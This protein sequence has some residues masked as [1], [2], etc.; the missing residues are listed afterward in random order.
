MVLRYKIK[1]NLSKIM[2]EEETM[3]N[4]VTVWN[5][6]ELQE[7]IK[8]HKIDPAIIPKYKNTKFCQA[9]VHKGYI[10]GT[11]SVISK[12]GDRDRA[13]FGF[14]IGPHN[15][16]FIDDTGVALACIN[17]IIKDKKWKVGSMERFLYDF[18]ETLIE[19]DLRYIEDLNDKLSNVENLIVNE[20]LDNFNDVMMG[21]RK[22]I[23][24]FHRYYSQLVDVGKEF[25]EN[26]NGFFSKESIM[27]FK[28]FTD[29][30]QQLKEEAQVLREYSTQTLEIYHSQ[31]DNVQNRIMKVLTIVTTIFTPV[32]ILSAWYGM[33][34]EN[35]PELHWPYGYVAVIA[36]SILMSVLIM[37]YINHKKL[38]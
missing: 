21:L 12:D 26:E 29:R 19:H 10:S 33:N 35:M 18:L 5:E 37:W 28:L 15:I 24:M 2:Q 30:A 14:V 17:R 7:K 20:E 11:F 38:L 22:E 36:A 9:E 32:S 6:A 25:Q 3:G 27:L 13:N 34:F 23:T 8:Q 4:I 31:V 1:N 16:L